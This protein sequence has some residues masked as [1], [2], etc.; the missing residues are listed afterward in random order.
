MP[1][2]INQNQQPYSN[3]M[4]NYIKKLKYTKYLIL[5]TRKTLTN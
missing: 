2:P 1:L 5:K 3:Y 4:E